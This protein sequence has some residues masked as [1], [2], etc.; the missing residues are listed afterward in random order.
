M[1]RRSLRVV[2]PC[3]ENFEAM[4]G[5]GARRFCGKCER[6][7]TDLSALTER[8][9]RRR[10]SEGGGHMCIRYRA[11]SDGTVL[12]RPPS[13]PW[14]GLAVAF[15]GVMLAACTGHTDAG[16]LDS[17]DDALSCH[18]ASGYS[19]AC[20]DRGAIAVV[21]TMVPVD[22]EVPDVDTSPVSPPSGEATSEA[23]ESIGPPPADVEVAAEGEGCPVPPPD[24]DALVDDGYTMG[25]PID[26]R[27]VLMGRYERDYAGDGEVDSRRAFRRQRRRARRKRRSRP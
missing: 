8:E 26:D 17:P 10:L 4:E 3:R 22:A 9:A 18:D 16:D 15:A 27:D 14:P 6:Q 21:P 5:R 11:A 23:D 24:P 12:F 19:I 20:E 1:H 2:E 7:V 13:R 25:V